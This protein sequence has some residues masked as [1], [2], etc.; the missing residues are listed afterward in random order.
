MH[1]YSSVYDNSNH[2]H[3]MSAVSGDGM[4]DGGGGEMGEA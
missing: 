4:C 1:P 3:V 2:L